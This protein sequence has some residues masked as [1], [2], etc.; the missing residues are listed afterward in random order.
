LLFVGSC[1]LSAE[2]ARFISANVIRLWHHNAVF[3]VGKQL[4]IKRNVFWFAI[5]MKYL[6]DYISMILFVSISDIE[7]MYSGRW[8]FEHSKSLSLFISSQMVFKGEYLQNSKVS[9]P[10]WWPW[11]GPEQQ[12][13]FRNLFW[14][15]PRKCEKSYSAESS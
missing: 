10:A 11:S 13:D 6:I 2:L 5:L 3:C 15:C 7:M 14:F 4:K 8:F 12:I 1:L 9:R